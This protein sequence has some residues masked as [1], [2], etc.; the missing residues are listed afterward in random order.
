MQSG[1]I[2]QCDITVIKGKNAPKPT[3]KHHSATT[4]ERSSRAS[5]NAEMDK[6]D[7]MVKREGERDVG[8]P[9]L[10]LCP[11][12]GSMDISA[13]RIDIPG[14]APEV[15]VC[16][17]CGFRSESAVEVPHPIEYVEEV[18]EDERLKPKIEEI[19]KRLQDAVFLKGGKKGKEA[20]SG[21][22]QGKQ[23]SKLQAKPQVKVQTAAKSS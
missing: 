18:E 17:R 4:S 15:Q 2:G 6:A 13:R 22:Q 3:K 12:C 23:Q 16:N 1:L 20:K 21:K 7:E 5:Y 19:E 11:R 10:K 14:F 8:Q 9:A